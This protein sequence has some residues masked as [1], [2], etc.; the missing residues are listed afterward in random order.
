MYAQT[1]LAVMDHNSN[2]SRKQALMK[3]NE[4][5]SKVN[6]SK[7]MTNWAQSHRTKIMYVYHGDSWQNF[8]I[9]GFSNGD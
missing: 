1:Q 4:L 8:K 7:V 2:P 6:F 3:N 9:K 5:R